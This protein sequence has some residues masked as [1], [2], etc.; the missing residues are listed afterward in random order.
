MPIHAD[1]DE[2]KKSLDSID[3]DVPEEK[4]KD[5]NEKE[6]P[7]SAV[8][9]DA[10]SESEKNLGRLR[11]TTEQ[12]RN[13]AN[14]LESEDDSGAQELN[15][16]DTSAPSSSPAVTSGLL[17]QL[18]SSP[19]TGAG[20]SGAN[21]G[22]QQMEQLRQMAAQQQ[23]QQQV[24]AQQQQMAAQ[25]QAM[26]QQWAAQQQQQMAQQQQQAMRQQQMAAQQQ[27][28]Q[29]QWAAQQQA[30]I[31]Q[32]IA[33]QQAAALQQQ[34]QSQQQAAQN[35]TTTTPSTTTTSTGTGAAQISNSD[36]AD[37]LRSIDSDSA[38]TSDS[39]DIETETSS[40]EETSTSSDSSDDESKQGNSYY[41]DK[42]TNTVIIGD[43]TTEQLK[44]SLSQ[45]LDEDG[46][47]YTIDSKGGR[48]IIEGGDGSGLAAIRARKEELGGG[49][50][51][52][53]WFIGLG[54]ND[55]NNIAAN[56]GVNQ[57]DRIDQV[58]EELSDQG[59]VYWPLVDI[60]PDANTGYD[61]GPEVDEFNQALRDAEERYPNLRVV[62]WNPT[63]DKYRDGIHYNEAGMEERV[64]LIA[65]TIE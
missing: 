4:K 2:V 59:M 40:D 16:V 15:A 9:S 22:A 50:E 61:L 47:P 31:Q 30:A 29:Q 54:V 25:Q 64:D 53:N 14:E 62:S 28:M 26:Q 38:D 19:S 7:F 52:T 46:V 33:Q 35:T 3:N 17:S 32:Q 42:A 27:M 1:T 23:A 36:L 5:E 56:S 51:D 8:S 43:S 44:D 34:Q 41:N 57:A 49:G 21:S 48:A 24:A 63:D 58:M 10:D 39:S 45:R 65:D 6:N 20:G 18:N 55:A 12:I 37:I 13:A 60:S 11:E